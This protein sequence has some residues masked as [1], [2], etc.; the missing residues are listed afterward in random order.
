MDRRHFPIKSCP[1]PAE[2]CARLVFRIRPTRIFRGSAVSLRRDLETRVMD[3]AWSR[4]IAARIDGRR[5]TVTGIRAIDAA[6]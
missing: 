5:W 6:R 2:R 3:A 1:A 4:G